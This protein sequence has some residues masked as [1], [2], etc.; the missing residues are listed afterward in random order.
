MIRRYDELARLHLLVGQGKLDDHQRD[1]LQ[2][3]RADAELATMAKRDKRLT[4]WQ[5]ALLRER[6]RRYPVGDQQVVPTMLGNAIRRLE[7]YGYER[8]RLDS[9]T[10]WY[11][12]EAVAPEHLI[13]QVDLAR[14]G[15]DFFVSLLYGHLIV[16]L[17]AAATFIIS[18]RP[19]WTLLATALVLGA[20][21]PI[22][23]RLAVHSTDDW[24]QA[25]RA[26]VNL[27]RKP[28]A[29][30]LGLCLPETIEKERRMWELTSKLARLP[31]HERAAELDIFR[32]RQKPGTMPRR[33]SATPN[34]PAEATRS[35]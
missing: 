24:S 30:S 34:A 11:E 26:L 3:L 21:A 28:L 35:G 23:Y 6:L 15:V 17:L 2:Q 12:L 5:R 19:H 14:T 8:F 1:R 29:E 32:A 31:Y 7:E 27:G 4:A 9:Q 18:V 13:K 16:A 33:R 25:V 20:L 22:W 10:L